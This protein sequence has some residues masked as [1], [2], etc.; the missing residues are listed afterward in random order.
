MYIQ[1]SQGCDRKHHTY[2]NL[3]SEDQC[4]AVRVRPSFSG[5][6]KG[7]GS[8]KVKI[9]GC[10]SSLETA[11]LLVVEESF[12][13]EDM[14]KDN[15]NS[16]EADHGCPDVEESSPSVSRT[17]GMEGSPSLVKETHV[18]KTGKNQPKKIFASLF[19]DKM[20]PSKPC[21]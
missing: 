4:Y 16:L 10:L 19:V 13:E 8:R 11:L 18:D 21:G 14:V 20:N 7:T 5:D 15:F 2:K 3:F 9:E 6:G 17:L 1:I 12:S